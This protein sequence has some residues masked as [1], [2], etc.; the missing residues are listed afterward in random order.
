[1]TKNSDSGG[2]KHITTSIAAGVLVDVGYRQDETGQILEKYRATSEPNF[3]VSIDCVEWKNI[4]QP[5]KS[6]SSV[7]ISAISALI[8]DKMP[9]YDRVALHGSAV[10]VDGD[11]YLFVAP[12]KTG[13]ST[14]AAWWRM[15]LGDHAVMINDDMPFLWLKNDELYLC[16]NFNEGKHHLGC[17]VCVPLK[18]V[19]RLVRGDKS[20]LQE[21]N[22]VDAAH[23]LHE[24]AYQAI[25]WATWFIKNINY[26]SI[27]KANLL[28]Q[29][30][31]LVPF[32]R[33]T[34]CNSYTDAFEAFKI[35]PELFN[36]IE[37]WE[38]NSNL[39]LKNTGEPE[40]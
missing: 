16:N 4:P 23:V 36:K 12:S 20:E 28:F 25:A 40:K 6:W 29:A 24:S 38:I 31:K 34:C 26:N 18:A 19:Y 3:S 32:Y 33:L 5:E 8:A 39:R 35:A 13:K 1:M 10:A 11:G 2:L 15:L 30:A 27:R 21:L 9:S 22:A 14:H 7:E 37:L 17:D